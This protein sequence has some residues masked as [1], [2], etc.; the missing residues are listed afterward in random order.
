M[1]GPDIAVQRGLISIPCGH[2]DND[3]GPVVVGESLD[4][5]YSI[6]NHGNTELQ[7]TGNPRIELHGADTAMFAILSLPAARIPPGASE[8]FT[9]RFEPTTVGEKQAAFAIESDDGDENPYSFLLQASASGSPE[10]EIHVLH[11][12]VSMR[13]GTGEFDF[14]AIPVGTH[15]ETSFAI[16]NIGSQ[17]LHLLGE[18]PV[19]LSGAGA[20]AF[21]ITAMPCSLLGTGQATTLTIRFTPTSDEGTGVTVCIANDDSTENPFILALRGSGEHPEINLKQDGSDLPSGTG[22]FDFGKQRVGN[23]R[24][25]SFLIQ[26]LGSSELQLTG[27]PLVCISGA[28]AAD[29]EVIAQP[30]SP[31]PPGGSTSFS[32]RYAPLSYGPKKAIASISSSDADEN[33]YTVELLGSSRL[34]DVR[35]SDSAYATWQP[36]LVWTGSGYGVAWQDRRSGD[37][38]IY[39]AR[40]SAAGRKQGEDVRISWAPG[41]SRAPRLVWAGAE[42][43]V[44][45]DD[46]R[47]GNQEIYFA[48]V[49]AS[50]VLQGEIRIT[51]IPGPA[52]NPS[53]VWTGSEFGLVWGEMRSEQADR[54]CFLR[55]S[56][57]GQIIGVAVPIAEADVFEIYP[58][59]VWTGA[60]YGVVWGQDRDPYTL[61][62]ELY[63]ARISAEGERIGEDVQV[64]DGAVL[65]PVRP[66]LVWTGS[67]YAMAWTESRDDS[68]EIIFARFSPT[69]ER[70]GEEVRITNA[71][72]PSTKPSLAWTGSGYGLAWEDQRNGSYGL[73]DYDIYFSLINAGGQEQGDDLQLV[74]RGNI[75]RVHDPSLAW[76]G[77][78]YGISYS[79]IAE[80]DGG[81]YFALLNELGVKQ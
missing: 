5:A 70:I 29:F 39:F 10:A 72:M 48:R 4:I 24:D 50:G 42:Y 34:L 75:A 56:A 32:I 61:P 43:A 9:V 78:G 31:I 14:G 60:E 16:Q 57:G 63:F 3:F 52:M 66:S 17:D 62:P 1:P 27:S 59:L 73:L 80:R 51:D 12:G 47:D 2:L 69:G 58:S 79:A 81:I 55:I 38:D 6:H 26:N 40:I 21:S 30:T 8:S 7:L 71:P 45:W 28:D 44:A 53:L 35:I 46:S 33:P 74:D 68:T 49:D 23:H 37:S 13:C 76:M 22:A 25:V 54:L 11:D 41:P 19:S 20:A 65:F 67:E 77:T 15:A 64:S 36:S 18:P